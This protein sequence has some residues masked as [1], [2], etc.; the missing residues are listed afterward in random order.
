MGLPFLPTGAT[1]SIFIVCEVI[2]AVFLEFRKR[3]RI[4]NDE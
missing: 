4:Q 1:N 3:F 2:F